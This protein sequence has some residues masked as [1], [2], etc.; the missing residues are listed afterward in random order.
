MTRNASG[1]NFTLNTEL[2]ALLA[3]IVVEFDG[4]ED[5]EEENNDGSGGS[6]GG[7]GGEG[8]E[9]GDGASGTGSNDDIKDPDKKRLSDEAAA[10]RVRAKKAEEALQE[11]QKRLKE[12]DDADKSELE[13]AQS[14]LAEAQQALAANETIIRDQAVRLAFFESGAAALFKNSVT[15][16]KLLDLSDLEV[17]DGEVDAKVIKERA[18]ALLKAEPY[19]AAD[20]SGTDG[21]SGKSSGGEPNNGRRKKD[22]ASAE[23]LK[24]KYPALASRV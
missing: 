19:L 17:K 6:D 12:I 4:G 5:E 20:G 2:S 14:E 11:A 13:K 22:D 18:E 23:K 16:R 3:D 8:G 1:R 7:E 15:A 24:G 9:G 21:S 10:Q